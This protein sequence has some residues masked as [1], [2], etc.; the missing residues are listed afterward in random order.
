MIE[1]ERPAVQS[2]RQANVR[3]WVCPAV[4]DCVVPERDIDC[5]Y[6]A[7]SADAIGP[8]AI[9]CVSDAICAMDNGYKYDEREDNTRATGTVRLFHAI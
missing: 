6:Q 9:D 5:S 4:H 7:R 2:Q 1:D 8:R 3:E